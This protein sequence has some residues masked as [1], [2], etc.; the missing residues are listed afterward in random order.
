[1]E[2]QGSVLGPL[3]LNTYINIIYLSLDTAFLGNYADNTTLYSIQ[4]NPKSNQAILNYDCTTLQKWF[5]ENYI[6]LNQSKCFYMCLDSNGFILEDRTKI[7]LTLEYKF[8]GIT[9]DTNLKL[10]SHLKQLCKEVAN[11]IN[12]LTRIIPYINKK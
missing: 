12:A 6:V 9:I 8:L 4:N 5:Y 2:S 1:M 10:Y 7:P 3:L 11:K